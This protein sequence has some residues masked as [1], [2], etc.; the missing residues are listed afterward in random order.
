MISLKRSLEKNK[1]NFISD[2]KRVLIEH[3]VHYKC[4]LT[5]HKNA[6]ATIEA[7]KK[8]IKDWLKCVKKEADDQVLKK[9]LVIEELQKKLACMKKM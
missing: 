2:E 5:A 7:L 8:H 9:Q 3:K 6:C 1:S 4:V